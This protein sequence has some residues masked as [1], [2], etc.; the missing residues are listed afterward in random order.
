MLGSHATGRLRSSTSIGSTSCAMTTS[1]AFFCSTRL[2]TWLIPNFNT[3]GFLP[4]VTSC[5]SLFFSAIDFKRSFLSTRV[6]GRYLCSNLKSW[7]AAER[8][9]GRVDEIKNA[10]S[11]IGTT[12]CNFRSSQLHTSAIAATVHVHDSITTPLCK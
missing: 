9:E 7:V 5:P 3:T 6:S 12:S 10:R 2:V 11:N 8:K 4:W 1:C